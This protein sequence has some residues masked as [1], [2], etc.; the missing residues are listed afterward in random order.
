M[1]VYNVRTYNKHTINMYTYAMYTQT[2]VNIDT[3]KLKPE[4]LQFQSSSVC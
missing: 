3:I 4:I 2:Y 1:N